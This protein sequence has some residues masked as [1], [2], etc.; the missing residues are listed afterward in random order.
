VLPSS[1]VKG[2]LLGVSVPIL[3][4]LLASTGI[5]LH[6]NGEGPEHKGRCS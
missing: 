4:D 2:H 6:S 3:S 5:Q 1:F